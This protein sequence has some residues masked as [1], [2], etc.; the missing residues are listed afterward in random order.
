IGYNTLN[1]FLFGV[2]NIVVI[3]FAAT[4][5]MGN[6][7]SI[8][9]FYAFM[10]YKGRFIS[11]MDSLI[12][13]WIEFKLLALHFNRLADIAFTESENIDEHLTGSLSGIGG[14]SGYSEIQGRI[15]VK[16]LSY[17]FSDLEPYIFKNI[18]F[19]IEAGETV[20]ITGPSGCGKTT[21]LK[22]LM[23]LIK[24]TEGEILIDGKSLDTQKH[25]RSQIAA[26]MQDD[27][28]IS[29]D[30]A[31]NIACFSPVVDMQKVH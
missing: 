2:E 25:Y 29:G 6:L 16:N 3:Y 31:E 20:A 14:D 4:A 23:G 13:Q 30:I 12:A 8:G 27:Q 18:N 22:C 7:I 15:E 10:S 26:V 9:M 17:R 11:S 28:L 24:P 1:G 21:L 5:V 19:T